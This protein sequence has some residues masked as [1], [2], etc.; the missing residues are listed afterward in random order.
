MP[1]NHQMIKVTER[2]C[3]GWLAVSGEDEPIKIGVTAPT[4][5]EAEEKYAEAIASW[6]AMLA[7]AVQ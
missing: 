7:Q 5:N 6:R 1:T 4:E 2:S 3:G